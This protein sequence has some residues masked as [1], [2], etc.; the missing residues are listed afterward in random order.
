MNE[1]A[2]N[3]ALQTL[4]N[5]DLSVVMLL[6]D[7]RWNTFTMLFPIMDH[8][9][10]R[11]GIEVI[12]I[13]DHTL[14]QTT[15]L[16]FIKRFS[17][18]DWK[19]LQCF[20]DNPSQRIN[21]GIRQS[22]KRYILLLQPD[23]EFRND[24]IYSLCEN[25]KYYHG[26]YAVGQTMD[27][28]Q[29][30]ILAVKDCFEQV[31]GLDET[32][33]TE[34]LAIDNL[35]RRMELAGISKLFYPGAEIIESANAI[36]ESQLSQNVI[37]QALLPTKITA[38]QEKW[39]CSSYILVHD[40]RNNP[41][42]GAQCKDYLSGLA[43]YHIADSNIFNQNYQLI[44]LIPTYHESDRIVDCLRSVEK[45]CDGIIV[46]DDESTDNTYELIQ[47]EKLLLKAKKKRTEF[48][49]KQ[50]RNILL[51][52]AYFFRSKWFIFIDADERFDERF[53]NLQ[54]IMKLPTVDVVSVWIANLWDSIE[55][56]RTN[57]TDS[58]SISNN[59]LLLRMRMFR[60][61]GRMQILSHRKLH[62][63]SIPYIENSCISRTL[64]IH[65][66]YLTIKKRKIK[67][68][69][70][71]NEDEKFDFNSYYHYNDILSE[72][73]EIKHL[74]ELSIDHLE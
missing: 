20:S 42:A 14:E 41:F 39:G 70:Y 46:L 27:G 55:T 65:L 26:Y 45:H 44:A 33:P 31:A 8:Y 10:Q 25:I 43:D 35:Q 16:T 21:I 32:I 37:I 11:N 4:Q 61:K 40:W 63:I 56:Y 15:V 24:V 7:N 29:A 18:I 13:A 12:V 73:I 23:W 48:N 49:D 9:Y 62:F 66:G 22:S 3:T 59:G 50:N 36:S 6:D 52:L 69:F 60:N 54:D 2:A 71:K 64:L 38:N 67:Y 53:V 19:V 68:D 30:A 58:H 5:F 72:K 47:S 28:K 17:M 34:T 1:S 57:M 51:D 74:N